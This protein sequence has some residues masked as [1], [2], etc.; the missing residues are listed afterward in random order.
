MSTKK[1]LS[2]WGA[3]AIGVG[4]MIGSGWL[5][6]A[7]YSAKYAGPASIF[8]WVIG[9][10]IALCLAFLLAEIATLYQERGL[11]ARLFTITHN[12]DCGFL[13]ALSNWL[14]LVI[15]IP[16]E[17]VATMQY[18]S[19]VAPR[20]TPYVFVNHNLTLLGIVI[21]GLL[22]I[23][24]GLIN[25]W[26]IRS[27]AKINNVITVIKILVPL[28]AGIA[29]MAA[30]FHPH[31][32]V[33][34]RGTIIPYGVGTV[35]AAVTNSGVFYAFFGYSLIAIFAKEIKNPK[36][37]IPLALAISVLICLLIYL[38]LQFAFIGALSPSMIAKGW[39]HLD[40]NS[41]LVQLALILDL[42]LLVIILYADS[43]LSPSGSGIVYAGSVMRV[44]TGMAKDRQMPMFFDN[45]H[46]VF[47]IS[48]RSMIFSLLLSFVLVFFFS[49]WQK[50]M[51]LVTVFQLISSVT[52][53]LAFTKLR[54][55]KP[56]E[57][58]LFRMPFGNI[59]SFVIYLLLT[60]LLT[61]TGTTALLMSLFLY[62]IFFL[63]YSL[64]YYGGKVDKLIRAFLSAWTIFTYLAFMTL[65]GYFQQIN[66]LQ[67]PVILVSFFIVA[68]IFY[69]LI[70]Q[71]KDFQT[72]TPKLIKA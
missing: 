42:N 20:F 54:Q 34:Y 19:T 60:F 2:L 43:A 1:Q 28:L 72:K 37:N 65:Y 49:N 16:S 61:Q 36:K 44:L 48:R 67:R 8:S 3:V 17:A 58:R 62:V 70:M 11:L 22:I 33:D 53:P 12:R 45:L 56:D 39:K 50:I 40:F 66:V 31:N 30:S 68:A 41:P 64:S 59:L 14:C 26:G 6:A 63:L 55:I 5:F 46:P 57:Y 23:G 69:W 32:F 35:F 47:N 51:L 13:V 27:L 21:V 71:Q 24:Y 29:I 25:F 38:V 9:A 15:M 4:S 52:I 7:Y 18:V 10:I